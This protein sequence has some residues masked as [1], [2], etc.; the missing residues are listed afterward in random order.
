MSSHPLQD[1]LEVLTHSQNWNS[2]LAS[3]DTLASA[4]WTVTPSTGVTLTDLGESGGV[5][6]AQVSGM[7]RGTTYKLTCSAVS[8]LGETGVRSLAIVCEQR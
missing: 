4:T 6:S 8:T 2:W 3:G 5:A 7:T 1:P